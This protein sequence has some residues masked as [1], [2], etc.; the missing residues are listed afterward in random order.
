MKTAVNTTRF[1]TYHHAARNSALS[2]AK[3]DLAKELRVYL[4]PST[5]NTRWEDA[6]AVRPL[7][8]S[9]IWAFLCSAVEL[10]HASA[11]R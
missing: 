11:H 9:D 10:V 1:L 4:N 2:I 5:P 6:L 8:D 7:Q 3:G